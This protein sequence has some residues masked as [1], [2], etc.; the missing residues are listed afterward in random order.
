VVQTINADVQRVQQDPEVLAT[1]GRL[2]IQTRQM[3]AAEFGG[4]VAREID[5]HKAIATAAKIE[6]Q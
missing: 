1:F 6:A 2:G 4:F 5:R 3:S